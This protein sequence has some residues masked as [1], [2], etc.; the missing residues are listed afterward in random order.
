MVEGHGEPDAGDMENPKGYG[1]FR[2]ALE[3]ENYI[4]KSVLLATQ[5][6]V[7]DDCNLRDR[8]PPR[9]SRTSSRRSS[10]SRTTCTAAAAR[11]FLLAARRGPEL[12]PLLADYGH[13]GRQRRRRRSSAAPLPGSGA[14]RRADRPTTTA[15]HPITEGFTQRTIFR[16]RARST[17]LPTA[18]P[19]SRPRRSSRPALRAGRRPTSTA[20]FNKGQA[21]LDPK[22]DRK[23]PISIAVAATV[24]TKHGRQGRR[25][26]PRRVRQRRVR[27]QQVP[28][29]TSTTAT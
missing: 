12:V 18:S 15:Q 26:A 13:S 17:P 28:R 20:L 6:K 16:S 1:G 2:T 21:T 8:R 23:G 25:V 7:P 10:S 9:R 5:E 19:A 14:R 3:N 29:A 22:T 27:R 11:V 4:T 24:T